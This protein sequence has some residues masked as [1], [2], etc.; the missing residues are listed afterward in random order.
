M[1]K[2]FQEYSA[3]HSIGNLKHKLGSRIFLKY[4][5]GTTK[6]IYNATSKMRIPLNTILKKN[7]EWILGKEI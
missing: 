7:V 5:N 2:Y 1:M 3:D 4:M 6:L